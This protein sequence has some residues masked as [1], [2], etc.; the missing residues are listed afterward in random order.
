MNAYVS[1]PRKL[2]STFFSL[3]IPPPP[4][5]PSFLSAD[6]FLTN[7]KGEVATIWNSF[8]QPV[9]PHIPHNDPTTTL[10]SFKTLED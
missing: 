8:T 6:D 9:T 7:F 1:N 3:L 10:S 4:P 5:S 2:F